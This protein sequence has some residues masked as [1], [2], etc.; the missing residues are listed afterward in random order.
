MLGVVSFTY[1]RP[2]MIARASQLLILGPEAIQQLNERYTLINHKTNPYHHDCPI[3][4]IPY[5]DI[6][7]FP[8]GDEPLETL[9]NLE[10]KY[11]PDMI[12][13]LFPKELSN[14]KRKIH[15]TINFALDKVYKSDKLLL[16][17]PNTRDGVSATPGIPNTI[18]HVVQENFDFDVVDNGNLVSI[19]IKKRSELHDNNASG[20][21]H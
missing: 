17:F 9:H 8:Y 13:K 5:D 19:I 18:F 2:N 4:E 1:L 16:L 7:N 6:R 20:S 14:V 12:E 11:S 15:N 3:Y 21:V 10:G